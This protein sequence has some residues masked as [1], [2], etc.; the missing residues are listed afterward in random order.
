MEYEQQMYNKIEQVQDILKSCYV[1]NL[2]LVTGPSSYELSGAK[3]RLETILSDYNVIN[4]S[5]FSKNPK[6][7]DLRRGVDIFRESKSTLVL[8][9]GGGS[10]L[11]MGKSISLLAGQNLDLE[12]YV[13]KRSEISRD[14]A[15]LIAVPTTAGSGSESTHFAVVYIDKMKYSLAHS[16]MLPKYVVLDAKL[17]ESLPS[18]ITASTTMDA[19]SQAMESYWSVGS[20]DESKGYAKEAM[21]IVLKYAVKNF[22]NPDSMSREKM[23]MAAN[24]AGRAIN[25]SKTTASHAIS[26]TFTSYFGIAHGHAVGLTLASLF[27][28][29]SKISSNDC[30]DSRGIEYVRGVFSDLREILGANSSEDAKKK[31]DNMMQ[32]MGLETSLRK[33]EIGDCSELVVSNVNLER[34]GN[35]PRKVGAEEIRKIIMSIQ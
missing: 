19:Y 5:N 9:V 16:S 2:L 24:L 12:E 30:N 35:N 13:T 10:V 14:G 31:I 23:Q 34:L 21:E 7:E 6:L 3:A 29:N 25:I 18:A 22:Q 4:F 32:K 8:A 17:T 26:Y 1:K 28:Y 33:L 27:D 15:P 20:T 11:D